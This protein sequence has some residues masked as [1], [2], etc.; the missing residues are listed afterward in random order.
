[1]PGSF[2]EPRRQGTPV[3]PEVVSGVS[4][5]YQ[6]HVIKMF[7]WCLMNFTRFQKL[8]GIG[9]RGALV[10]LVM[11]AAAAWVDHLLGH[12]TLST[13]AAPLKLVGMGLVVAGL[14]LHVWTLWTLRNWWLNDM[15]C[16]AG[17][18]KWLR[19]PMCAAW[20]TFV[21]PGVALFLNSRVFLS[22]VVM[23]HPVWHQLVTQEERMM[24]EY[25]RDEYRMY[26]ARTGRFIPGILNRYHSSA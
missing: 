12:P 18:F 14:G 10:S 26:S 19:H 16:T 17:P 25:F 5:P 3:D 1:M 6:S 22:R 4:P 11:L 13:P 21:S 15:L 24:M 20:I 7:C 23:L 8:F 2:R 9:P